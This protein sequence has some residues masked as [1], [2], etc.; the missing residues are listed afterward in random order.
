MGFGKR[1]KAEQSL[2]LNVLPCWNR[3]SG[4]GDQHWDTAGPG[5]AD[6]ATWGLSL[7]FLTFSVFPCASAPPQYRELLE[8]LAVCF[9]FHYPHSGLQ[10]IFKR[11]RRLLFWT[12]SRNVWGI[13]YTKPP[14]VIKFLRQCSVWCS[15]SASGKIMALQVTRCMP[16]LRLA[17]SAA[18]MR[19]ILLFGLLW[20]PTYWSMEK[21]AASPETLKMRCLARSAPLNN[22]FAVINV[23]REAY[24]FKDIQNAILKINKSWHSEVRKRQKGGGSLY[25][26]ECFFPVMKQSWCLIKTSANLI[27]TVGVLVPIT[28]FLAWFLERKITSSRICF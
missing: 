10:M 2:F 17:R 6:E 16:D 9:S 4:N 25:M 24:C 19:I 15:C 21:A 5:G 8:A 7:H 14:A 20:F 11:G 12:V 13:T 3:C 18:R 23:L 26:T 1:G 28:L 27:Y 22:R